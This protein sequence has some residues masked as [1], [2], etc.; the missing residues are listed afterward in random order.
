MKIVSRVLRGAAYFFGL[1][2]LAVAL[3]MLVPRGPDEARQTRV[4]ALVILGSGPVELRVVTGLIHTDLAIP[5]DRVPVEWLDRFAAD[6]LPVDNPNAQWLMFGWGSRAIYPTS[7][8]FSDMRAGALFKAF[9]YDQ[10]SMRVLV[11]GEV[12][13][14]EGTRRHDI[15][16]HRF[17]SL[18]GAI[19]DGFESGVELALASPGYGPDDRFYD[20]TGWFNALI[21]CNT[22]A[23]A[24]LRQA[25]LTTGWWNPLPQTLLVSMDLYN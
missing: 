4:D 5:I 6:G 11:L 2:I 3:G 19:D 17:W 1:A 13:W 16:A 23:A 7:P 10:A 15:G 18:L 21:G 8:Q 14:G 9:T 22:W 25:G 20:G 12:N 24:S